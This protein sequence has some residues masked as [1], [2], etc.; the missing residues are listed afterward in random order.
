MSVADRNRIETEG[1]GHLLSFEGDDRLQIPA[2]TDKER[3]SA[4]RRYWDA[5]PE[6]R[7]AV[8]EQY[9]EAQKRVAE[10]LKRYHG[11]PSV[12]ARQRIQREDPGAFAALA[13]R[14]YFE[15]GGG[16]LGVEMT[17]FDGNLGPVFFS[18]IS[19]IAKASD[20]KLRMR[21]P[22][23]VAYGYVSGSPNGQSELFAI[24]AGESQGVLLSAIASSFPTV[25][26]LQTAITGTRL[27]DI[28]LAYANFARAYWDRRTEFAAP[29]DSPPITTSPGL[30]HQQLAKQTFHP[31]ARV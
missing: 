20:N 5:W 24:V 25:D 8:L 14:E 17:G 30:S 28:R 9:A 13:A 10:F 22:V 7:D 11:K 15:I 2:G 12:A 6:N 19:T 26:A 18:E 16:P 31:I 23:R 3:V 21:P 1:R 4:I 27:D 29:P